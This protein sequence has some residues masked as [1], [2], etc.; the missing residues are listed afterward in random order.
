M[1]ESRSRNILE[2]LEKDASSF[3]PEIEKTLRKIK[4]STSR[5]EKAQPE[6]RFHLKLV[7]VASSN[8]DNMAKQ[9]RM[10]LENVTIPEIKV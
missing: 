9:V 10:L 7:K 8:R 3:F 1:A 4:E 5:L 2:K 6:G